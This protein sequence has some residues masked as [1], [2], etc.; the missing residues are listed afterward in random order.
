MNPVGIPDKGK[1]LTQM[2][3]FWFDMM[4]SIVTNHLISADL[5]DFPED[6]QADPEQF[7]RR[8]AMLVNKCDMFPVEFV[9]RGYLAGRRVERDTRHARGRCAELVACRPC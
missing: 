6:F 5:A 1:I 7:A 3:L 8:A 2:S 9:V 4:R